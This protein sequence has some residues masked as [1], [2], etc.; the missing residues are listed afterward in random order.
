MLPDQNSEDVVQP[1]STAAEHMLR[2]L[3]AHLKRKRDG[4]RRIAADIDAMQELGQISGPIAK[5]L[6]ERLV[7]LIRRED[8][9]T[10]AEREILERDS[11][12]E[13]CLRHHYPAMPNHLVV[14][15]ICIIDGLSTNEIASIVF[16]SVKA[17]DHYRQEIRQIVGLHGN[18]SSLHHH[19]LN[20]IRTCTQCT[21]EKK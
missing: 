21:P 19:L 11:Q 15:C 14:V 1:V 16:K 20:V 6:R 4:I 10:W 17:V 2:V 18:R 3:H 13:C 7:S 9:L 5:D 12:V 8:E